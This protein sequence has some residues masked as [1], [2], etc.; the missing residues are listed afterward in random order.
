[1]KEQ[2]FEAVRKIAEES[3]LLGFARKR[4]RNIFFTEGKIHYMLEGTAK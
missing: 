4:V 2:L 1:M 3:N